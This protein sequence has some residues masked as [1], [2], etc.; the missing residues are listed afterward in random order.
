MNTISFWRGV[1]VAFI[2][3]FLG[4]IAFSVFSPIIGSAVSARVLLVSLSLIYLV[5]LL[6]QSRARSGKLLSVATWLFTT[7]LLFLFNPTI[8]LWLSSYV[9]MLWVIRCLYRYGSLWTAGA[10]AL[11]NG[12][13]LLLAL[14]TAIHT[15][16]VFLSLWCFFL[17]QALYVY[18][19]VKGSILRRSPTKDT[20]PAAS[21]DRF[22]RAYRTADAAF[23]RLSA[24]P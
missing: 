3:S 20:A 16:S 11:L 17:V 6:Y 21:E 10:D 5:V 13:A 15:H 9:G 14:A 7:A 8:L 19:P 23:K 4:A 24:R 22:E 1:V 2:L 12:L 18:I